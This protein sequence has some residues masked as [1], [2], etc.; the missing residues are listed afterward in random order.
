[1]NL[2]RSLGIMAALA[3]T[4]QLASA[5]DIIGKVTLKGTPPPEKELPLDPNCG[6]LHTTKPKTRFYV[7]G[8]NNGLADVFVYIKDGL[9]G[10]TF[11]VPTEAALLDQ[12][13][14]EYLPY[15][16]GLQTNQKLLVRNS[17]PLL[18]NVHPTP[19]VAGNKEKNLAQMPKSKDLEFTFP[20]PEI[21]VRYK[22]DV[23]PWMFAYVGV[24]EHPFYAVS[25]KD[26]NF[27][28]ANVPPGD[29]TVEAYHR[30]GG[31]VTQQVKVENATKTADFTVEVAESK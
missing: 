14:C 20:S 24:L 2:K 6:K 17:D 9:T 31:K 10:K 8:E 3:A 7:T 13:N 1:M 18:H 22:C 30:K 15:V 28:I 25:D 26:G 4:V 29:Y 11:E 27:K 16:M 21:F 5:A 12:K 23:H 19:T